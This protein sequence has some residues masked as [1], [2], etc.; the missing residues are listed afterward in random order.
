MTDTTTQTTSAADWNTAPLS[1]LIDHIHD[2]HHVFLREHLPKV[3]ARL[4]KILGKQPDKIC[5]FIP[6]LARTFFALEEDLYSHLLKEEQVLFPYVKQIEAAA[7]AGGAAPAFHCGTVAAPIGQM[8][9]EHANGKRALEELRRLTEGY[10]IVEGMCR[11]RQGLFEDLLAL[12]KDLLEHM[13][14]END[15][16]HVRALELERGFTSRG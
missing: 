7:E 8:E 1:E 6:D 15:I 10:P 9:H 14:K 12:E 11:N 4:E 16:L 3:R 13:H 2:K 5:G